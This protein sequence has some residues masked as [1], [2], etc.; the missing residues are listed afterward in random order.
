MLSEVA[1]GSWVYVEDR[2]GIVA[3]CCDDDQVAVLVFGCRY[4]GLTIKRFAGSAQ[5]TEI[6]PPKRI[7]ADWT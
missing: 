6:P 4:E 2:M 3:T 1:E 5:V 7:A